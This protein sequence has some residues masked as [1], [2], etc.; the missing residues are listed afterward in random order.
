MADFEKLNETDME[1][2]TGGD[3]S[4][5]WNT[6]TVANLKNGYLALRTDPCY[7]DNEVGELS[8]G[9]IVRISSNTI[10]GTDV[11]GNPC[12]YVYV[13]AEKSG[14]SGYVNAAFLQ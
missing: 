2:V 6:R 12:I 11:N 14:I 1:E 8:N 10:T 9:D 13:Y 4:K 3:G 5:R 7:D